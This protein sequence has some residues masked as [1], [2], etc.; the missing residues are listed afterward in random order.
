MSIERGKE[1]GLPGT[2]SATGSPQGPAAVDLSARP[3]EAFYARQKYLF[4]LVF[5]VVSIVPL[6]I[7]NYNAAR[8]YRASWIEKTTT[9]IITMANDRKALIDRFL[10]AQEDQLAGF[11]ALN[12]AHALSG[13]RRLD[14]L[15]KV[16]SRDGV[17]SDIGLIDRHGNHLAYRGPYEKELAGK[18]YAAAEWFVEVMKSGRYAS[19]VF[20]GYRNVP[21]MII[22]VA[23]PARSGILRATINSTFFNNLVATANVGPD[24]DAFIVNRSGE[25]QTPSRLGR[26]AVTPDEMR[27]FAALAAAGGTAVW[28][29]DRIHGATT[30]NDGQW[31]L[32]LE[33]NVASS[34]A[35]YDQ[36]RQRDTALMA[37]AAVIII[38][39][40]VL[41][42]RSMVGSL[43]RA[44]REHSM[45]THQVREVEKLALIGRLSASVAHEINNPLQIISD[46]AGLMDELMDD[47]DP[48]GIRNFTDYRRA[49][50]KIRDQVKRTST[51]T[52]RLLGFS[53]PLDNSVSPTDINQAVDETIALLEHEAD[54]QRI[55]IA[56]HYQEDLPVVPV[57]ASQFQQVVLNILHNA[58]D[59]IGRGG[60]IDVSSRLEGENVVVEFADTGPGLP[61]EVIEHL[62][63]PFFTTKPK[64][65]GTGLG[66][67]VSRDIMARSGGRLTAANGPAGGAVFTVHLPRAGPEAGRG[68]VSV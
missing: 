16:L 5:V 31:L 11:L 56:R 55:V 21:H 46:Q 15:F 58:L 68:M 57:D 19:D 37:V 9:E 54:R 10:A 33:T 62:Y 59:A 24:G 17:I 29:D 2:G 22:A 50:G 6:L 27:R 14:A 36:A 49:V 65:K 45:L 67:F 30:L 42:T 13:D 52:R 26:D 64:G 7:L 23:D 34:L 4:A 61:P 47:E 25:F 39:V 66:L 63:D 40:A 48:H 35:S 3:R 12:S 28:Q 41:L 51:I 60:K 38:L 43:A 8:F 20:L 18:N 1:A 53:H 32:V 44:E